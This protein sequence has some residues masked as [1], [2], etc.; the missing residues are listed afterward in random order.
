MPDKD[1]SHPLKRRTSDRAGQSGESSI[2]AMVEMIY[3]DLQNIKQL[4]LEQSKTLDSMKEILG[5][6]DNTKGFVSTIKVMGRFIFW[7]STLGGAVLALWY[8]ISNHKG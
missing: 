1:T 4:N 8:L 5:I 2:K 3:E 7:L 6:W